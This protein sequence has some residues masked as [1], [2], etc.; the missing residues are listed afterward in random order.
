MDH[1]L[2]LYSNPI[3]IVGVVMVLAA[4]LLLQTYRISAHGVAYTLT[5]LIG[6][7]LILVSLYYHLNI[8]SLVIE[9]AWLLISLYGLI[10]ALRK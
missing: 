6:S 5:N 4:Y 7:V 3:G 9:I 1:Y 2:S 8:A 10:N